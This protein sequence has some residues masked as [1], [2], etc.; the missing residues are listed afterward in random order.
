MAELGRRG[1]GSQTSPRC[2]GS[3]HLR[4][5]IHF[6]DLIHPP[7]TISA[8]DWARDRPPCLEPEMPSPTRIDADAAAEKRERAPFPTETLNGEG[9]S[10]V[11]R[12]QHQQP[13]A[14]SSDHNLNPRTATGSTAAR[15]DPKYHRLKGQSGDPD[16]SRSRP[17][18]TGESRGTPEQPAVGM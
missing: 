1:G 10:G 18:P 13:H 3:L 12:H 8:A 2:S 11:R 7:D 15:R 14:H 9:P 16:P 4:S 17:D 5:Q 6:D